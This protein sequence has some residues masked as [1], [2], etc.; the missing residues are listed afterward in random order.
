MAT[1]VY[2]V[3]DNVPLRQALVAYLNGVEDIETCGEAGSCEEAAAALPGVAPSLILLDLSLPGRSGFDL[4]REVG[5]K[6]R[7][8]CVILSGHADRSHVGRAFAAG[9]RGYLLKGGPQ[10][11]ATAIRRVVAGEIYLSESLR[12]ALEREPEESAA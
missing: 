6:W 2:I 11:V 1:R 3:E 7:I 12:E 9:A 5:E 10:E 4:L 8:P